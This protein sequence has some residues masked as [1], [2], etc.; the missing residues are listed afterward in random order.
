MVI[1]SVYG[2][3]EGDFPLH[4]NHP[5]IEDNLEKCGHDKWNVNIRAANIA[6]SPSDDW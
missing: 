5:E 3:I 1:D 4:S 2:A 6:T